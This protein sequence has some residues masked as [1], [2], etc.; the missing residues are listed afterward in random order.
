MKTDFTFDRA[1]RESLHSCVDKEQA[2]EALKTRIDCARRAERPTKRRTGRVAII[3]AAMMAVLAVGA[4][5]ASQFGM[6]TSHSDNRQRLTYAQAQEHAQEIDPSAIV[7]EQLGALLY[8]NA[9]DMN[10][11][12]T[13]AAGKET[14]FKELNV[15]YQLGEQKASLSLSPSDIGMERTEEKQKPTAVKTI[16]G[17]TME[18][19]NSIYMAVPPSYK[20]SADEQA[21]I[22]AGTLMIGYGADKVETSQ[23]EYVE[24]TRDGVVYSLLAMDQS[25]GADAM[26]NMLAPLAA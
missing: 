10:S 15:K 8:E 5:A 1:L 7:P 20:P 12:A 25:F 22:E 26:F 3:A 14:P 23:M 9:V 16:G 19:Q 2:P 18:Y 11:V 13:D 24:F 6:I 21:Q 17:V 4:F